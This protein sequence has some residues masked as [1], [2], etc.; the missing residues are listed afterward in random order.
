MPATESKIVFHDP[1]ELGRNSGIYDEP[2][3]VLKC[4]GQLQ[5]TNYDGEESLC[6]GHSI[7][8][9]ALPYRKRRVIAD[10]AAEKYSETKPDILATACPACK[11]AFSETNKL[12]VKDLAEIVADNL[13]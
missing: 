9:E 11:K 1:C 2:R 7:A 12:E 8:A 13:L 4:V 10:D 5:S 3:E 6:C